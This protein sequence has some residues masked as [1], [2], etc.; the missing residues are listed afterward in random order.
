[1]STTCSSWPSSSASPAST[2][3]DL[4]QLR[5]PSQTASRS[6]TPDLE[7]GSWSSSTLLALPGDDGLRPPG[8]GNRVGGDLYYSRCDHVWLK[9]LGFLLFHSGQ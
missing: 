1:M 7:T 5:P 6:I 8:V 3:H 2:S 4:P 9:R